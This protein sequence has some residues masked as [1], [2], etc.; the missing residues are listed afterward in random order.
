MGLQGMLEKVR[1]WIDG[2]DDLEDKEKPRPHSKWE[3]FLVAIARD[4]E[5]SMLKE[6]F[7]PPGGPTYIPREYIVFL[8]P[9]DDADWQGEKREGLERGLHHVL[10]ERA[11]ELIGTKEFQTKNFV[12]ELR[13]DAALEPGHF[14]VQPVW[15]VQPQKTIVKPRKHAAPP[16][17][18]PDPEQE[19]IRTP[20]DDSTIVRPRSQKKPSI[21][22]IVQRAGSDPEA[23]SNYYSDEISIGRGARQVE[24]D[25]KLDGDM[26]ISRKHATLSKSKEGGYTITCHGAN[27]IIIAGSREVA[28]G[29]SA[30]VLPGERIEICSYAI[31]IQ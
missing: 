4:V 14:K 25:L 20:D 30:T 24:V 5:Q 17:V 2:E 7:T 11:R 18:K 3:D 16:Q 13:V 12:V 29:E 10:S 8:S 21:S 28:C 9:A 1:K 26:E 15:D 27:S 19:I 23:P 6:M 31:V 22:L